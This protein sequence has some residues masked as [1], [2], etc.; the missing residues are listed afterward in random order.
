[1]WADVF[2]A[3]LSGGCAN[4]ALRKTARQGKAQFGVEAAQTVQRDFYIDD[5]LKSVGDVQH[6][7]PLV[8]NVRHVCINRL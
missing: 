8:S 4:Y 5:W 2:G 6:A 3:V 7:I 1:M